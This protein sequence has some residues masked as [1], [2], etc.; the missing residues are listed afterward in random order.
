MD[1]APDEHFFRRADAH[2]D[3]ANGQVKDSSRGKVSASLMY[4]TARFN[5]WVTAC[6]AESA[7]ELRDNRAASIEYFVAQYR[8]MLEENLDDYVANF[9]SY[10]RPGAPDA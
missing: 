1:S 7:D 5:A 2:I 10:L 6:G 4:A 9:T 3:L 8:T